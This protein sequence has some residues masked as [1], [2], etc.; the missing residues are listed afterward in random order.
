MSDKI[1]PFAVAKE[2]V[3]LSWKRKWTFTG[4]LLFGI[5]PVMVAVGVTVM[6]EAQPGATFFLTFCVHLLAMLFLM[7]ASNHLAVT[8]QRGPGKVLPRPF[9]PAMGRVFVRGLILVGLVFAAMLVIMAPAA[10]MAYLSMPQDGAGFET[11]ALFPLVAFIVLAAYIFVVGLMI[12]L[13]VMIPGAA[14][15]VVVRVREALAMTRGHAWRMFWSMMLVVVPLMALT[16]ILELFIIL[17]GGGES[18]GGV[19][20]VAFLCL[21]VVDLFAWI[22]MLVQNA[23]WYEKLRLRMAG[24]ESGQ[25]F[26]FAPATEPSAAPYVGPYADLSEG[27]E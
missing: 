3:A 2:A 18:F 24:P 22:V 27:R 9:W 1:S 25:A 15:G 21:L 12:R 19:Q 20:A 4:L 23:V 26:E 10:V 7:T 11:T 8:M 5:V 14:V 16:L 6:S 17:P 13:S